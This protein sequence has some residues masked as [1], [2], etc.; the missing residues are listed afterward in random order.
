MH[1]VNLKYERKVVLF[2]FPE[3]SIEVQLLGGTSSAAMGRSTRLPSITKG[4]C[5]Y[6][7]TSCEEK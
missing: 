6:Y 2:Q 3:S 4:N 5:I 7:N 1:L